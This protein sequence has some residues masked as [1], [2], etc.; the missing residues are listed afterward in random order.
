MTHFVRQ[1]NKF[2]TFLQHQIA[3]ELVYHIIFR[4]TATCHIC[5][6]IANL[7]P[8]T[9]RNAT[10][11]PIDTLALVGS[12]CYQALLARLVIIWGTVDV[13]PDYP[14]S[15]QV[16][17]KLRKIAIMLMEQ[18]DNPQFF[19][20]RGD[21]ARLCTITHI[22]FHQYVAHRCASRCTC[23]HIQTNEP[24]FHSDDEQWEDN[25][26]QAPSSDI[27]HSAPTSASFVDLPPNGPIVLVSDSQSSPPMKSR[28]SASSGL[29]TDHL[30]VY[31]DMLHCSNM[32]SELLLVADEAPCPKEVHMDTMTHS[33]PED[34]YDRSFSTCLFQPPDFPTVFCIC[35]I[36][37]KL[38]DST[39]QIESKQ[40]DSTPGFLPIQC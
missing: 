3:K 17:A 11:P 2:A 24:T 32:P 39:H 13:M 37:V 40:A 9:F 29:P 4:T 26:A 33:S 15:S 35:K 20:F 38:D 5:L 14:S 18:V 22:F 21:M 30:V 8:A 7:E 36:L 19:A 10:N 28:K 16:H 23:R 1:V 12:C 31:G 25:I 27:P 34:M 6:T